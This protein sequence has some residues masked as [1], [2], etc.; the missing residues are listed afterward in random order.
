MPI[1]TDFSEVKPLEWDIYQ[2]LGDGIEPK[3]TFDDAIVR[4][5]VLADELRASG[6][7]TVDPLHAHHQLVRLKIAALLSLLDRNLHIHIG[8]RIW[9]MSKEVLSVSGGVRDH[10]VRVVSQ[11]R[12]QQPAESHRCSGERE[13]TKAEMVDHAAEVRRVAEWIADAVE[14]SPG[15]SVSDLKAR[16]SR[17][18]RR[19]YDEPVV[20]AKG[21][22]W[23]AEIVETTQT[24]RP[25]RALYP[26]G[27]KRAATLALPPL[28]AV[29]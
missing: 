19:V 6:K 20:H 16:C 3:L 21:K 14:E 7:V 11:H 17:P 9:A 8:S 5:I 25:K 13:A 12:K 1:A 15:I 10:A 24:D 26:E 29:P 22:G 2:I 4:G 23:V 27:S 28:S 18:K